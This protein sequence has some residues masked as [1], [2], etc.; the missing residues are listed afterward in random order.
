MV[1]GRNEMKL[2]RTTKFVPFSPHLDGGM[3]ARAMIFLR[4]LW[5]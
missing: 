4:F 2:G 5:S 1:N 3:S